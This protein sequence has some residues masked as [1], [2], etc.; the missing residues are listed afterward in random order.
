M[1]KNFISEKTYRHLNCTDGVLPRAYRL[2]KI[3][4]PNCSLRI[5]ISSINNPLFHLAKFLHGIIYDSVLVADSNV[6]NS[7]QLVKKLTGTYIDEHYELI[8]LDVVSLFTNIPLELALDNV[9]SKWSHIEK[10]YVLS[11][12]EFSYAVRFVLN[13]TYFSFD[14]S[15]YKQIFGTCTGLSTIT[16]HCRYHTSGSR[17]KGDFDASDSSPLL[18]MIC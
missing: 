1:E 13:S 17:E 8:S 5:I 12:D 18:R 9:S 10:K 11:R 4:K 6:T 15:F 2:P 16:N 14:G 3:H 7:F